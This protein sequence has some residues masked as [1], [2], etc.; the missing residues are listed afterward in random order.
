MEMNV[1]SE[2]WRLVRELFAACVDADMPTRARLLAD[3]SPPLRVEIETLL[4][5]HDGAA[6][7]E[8]GAVA[9]AAPLIAD[10][11][12]DENAGE[13]I[14]AFRTLEVIGRGGMGV[15]WLAERDEPGFR[16]RVA[17][18]RIRRGL[19]SPELRTRFRRERG[20]LARLAHDR[21]ARLLDGGVDAEGRP[22]LALEY[23][24]GQPITQWC[25]AH[26]LSLRER[27][28]LF[29]DVLDGVAY[30]HRNLVVHRDLKPANVL[31][32]ANGSV[33]LL[34]FGIA[35]LLAD[36]DV[37]QTQSGTQL[38][39][40]ACAAPEQI[41]GEAVSTATD[42]YA[43]GVLLYELACGVAP[44]RI[45]TTSRQAIARAVLEDVPQRPVRALLRDGVDAEAIAAARSTS[46][47]ALRRALDRDF[48]QIVE[49]TLAK[50][51]EQRYASVDAFVADVRAWLDRRPLL[52][53]PTPRLRR[54][55]QFVRRHRVGVAAGLLVTLTALM[56]V[57]ATAWQARIAVRNAATARAVRDF[58]TRLFGAID[59][60][61][62]RG[63]DIPL[64]EV[65]DEGAR[66]AG[67]EL[68]DTPE[69][70]GAM[71]SDL[72]AI[73]TSIGE[74]DRAI[75]LLEQARAALASAGIAGDE[76]PRTWLRLAEAQF[77]VTRLDDASASIGA[78]VTLLAGRSEH[79]PLWLQA[80]LVHGRIDAERGQLDA[81]DVR[82]T[83]VVAAMRAEPV[84]TPSD[85]SNALDSLA[86]LRRLQTRYEEALSLQTQALDLM[87]ASDPGSPAV[88]LRLHGLASIEQ[89]NAQ[90]DQAIAHLR[91][92]VALHTA[93][94]GP[95]HPLTAESEGELAQSL[96]QAGHYAEAE[97]MFVA[98]IALR[99]DIFGATNARV[100]SVLN[101]Y[102]V[103]LYAQH[104]Y[105]EAAPRFSQA[106]DI[107]KAALG[108][109][110]PNTRAALT[111][112]GG[113]L[114]EAGDLERAAPLLEQ[115][116]ELG[117]QIDPPRARVSARNTYAL[118]LERQNRLADAERILRTGLAEEIEAFKGDETQYT[119]TRT[120]FGRVLRERG[121]L[122]SA[123]EQ[124]EQALA[125]YDADNYPDGPRTAAC[126]L[127]LA[128]VR[129]AQGERAAAI[130]PL[131]ERALS[132]QQSKLGSDH[133]D[134]K[135]TAALLASIDSPS[136]R[137]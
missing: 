9:W 69:V 101:N 1:T 39:T 76:L 71:L 11:F 53:R 120:L 44:Y 119:W 13:R 62:A 93:V 47:A 105:A 110:H 86:E 60:E 2:P 18:K 12:D 127:Q 100:A 66:R 102:G 17:L 115:A 116:F 98:N 50:A 131:L 113:A 41:R 29:L 31:V 56:G 103:M 10:G 58:T 97:P 91:E 40:P 118:L 107:F 23:V 59:P 137:R 85:L 14:G 36:D 109:Q 48:A 52:S 7:L 16:Q 112:Y 27:A 34:D 114:L 63:R 84:I 99:K 121:N 20:I 21:I 122:L 78:A 72:G 67:N 90:T 49:I 92:A 61:Q 68:R 88:A 117:Q 94:R 111:G 129:R 3:A 81:A 125:G 135:A 82:L 8:A 95:R 54:I 104:R 28:R 70:R 25:D 51:P 22:W 124:L 33:K 43:L 26:R 73:Y 30:A 42:V 4:R 35:K 89:A 65:L 57:T 19:D 126:L 75:A 64:R 46:V 38:L 133:P 87:R 5:A 134:T 6:D 130:R 77:E 136:P 37:E 128:L 79:D 123:R 83:H 106:W 96:A 55:A 45:G 80:E 32:D 15:V 24:A 108:T 132:T 74:S